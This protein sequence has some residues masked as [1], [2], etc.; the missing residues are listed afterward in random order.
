M[1]PG[2]D[3]PPS[4]EVLFAR[5]EWLENNP[6]TAQILVEEL[7]KVWRQINENP[8]SIAE[9]REKYNLL[10]D[11]PKELEAEIVPFYTE[12]AERG[13]F[14]TDGGNPESIK[15]DF[16]FYGRAGQLEGDPAAFKIEDFWDLKPLENARAAVD[17]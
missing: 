10:P 16:D 14:P 5:Q 3:V 7:L 2:I 1:L 6:E 4:D 9:L 12:G 15:T 17:G 13:L 11:L 8:A